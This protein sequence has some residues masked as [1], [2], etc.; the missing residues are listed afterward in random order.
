MRNPSDAFFAANGSHAMK[1][2]LG[3]AKFLTSPHEE[4]A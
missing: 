1:S 3:T 2:I 4:V